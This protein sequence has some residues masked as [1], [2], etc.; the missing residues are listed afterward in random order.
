M[1]S[2]ILKNC[3]DFFIND[4]NNNNINGEDEYNS[5]EINKNDTEINNENDIDIDNN[6]A[7]KQ[8][9]MSRA[10][11]RIKKKRE[12]NNRRTK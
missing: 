2:K 9:R 10:M 5:N 11:E 6:N 4:N 3:N 7:I 1:I 8:R 12:K